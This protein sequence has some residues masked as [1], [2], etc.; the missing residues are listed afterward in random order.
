MRSRCARAR[1]PLS[2]ERYQGGRDSY[3]V[4]L[5]SQRIHYGAQQG[6]IVIRLAEQRNRVELYRALGGGWKETS[7]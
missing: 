2:R 4:A 6:L 3:L 1:S 5:D 7:E